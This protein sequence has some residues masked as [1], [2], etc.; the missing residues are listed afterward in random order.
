MQSFN[1]TYNMIPYCTRNLHKTG[2]QHVGEVLRRGA[3]DD[4]LVAGLP[5][6]FGML[7]L[8]PATAFTWAVGMDPRGRRM[9]VPLAVPSTAAL[10]GLSLAMQPL[11]PTAAAPFGFGSATGLVVV[12]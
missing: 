2:D 3:E 7:M 1:T 6:P 11:A 10:V 5:T 8:D 9:D 12:R 4:Q